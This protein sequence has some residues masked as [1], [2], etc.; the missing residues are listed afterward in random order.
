[1]DVVGNSESTKGR[2]VSAS[3]L[4]LAGLWALLRVS[5]SVCGSRRRHSASVCG[6]R[7]RDAAGSRAIAAGGPEDGGV[8]GRCAPGPGLGAEPSAP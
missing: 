3:P 2:I 5:V 4:G 1:M 6:V 7:V 8:A